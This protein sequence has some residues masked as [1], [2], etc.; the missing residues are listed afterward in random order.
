MN[1]AHNVNEATSCIQN[2]QFIGFDN[3]TVDLIYGSPTTSN[4]QWKQNVQQ[5]FDFNIPHLSCY[6]LTVEPNTA[7]DNFVKKGKAPAVD[8]EKSA[9]QFEMLMQMMEANGYDHYEISNFA[10]PDMH[11]R[12]LSLIHI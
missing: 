1:R 3:L 12:H 6:C 7:L 4:T 2:A 10:K 9:Q 11:A 8:E 5:L